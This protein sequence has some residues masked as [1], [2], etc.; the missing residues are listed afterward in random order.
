M[1]VPLLDALSYRF[2]DGEGNTHVYRDSDG[3][4]ETAEQDV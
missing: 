1:S 4:G 3:I 2:V